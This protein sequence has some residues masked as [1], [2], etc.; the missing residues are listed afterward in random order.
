[1]PLRRPPTEAS[2]PAIVPGV[3]W[4]ITERDQLPLS[5]RLEATATPLPISERGKMRAR[6][7]RDAIFGR[8]VAI[9]T[10]LATR[11]PRCIRLDNDHVHG[12]QPSNGH[13]P[14]K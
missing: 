12:T 7:C 13:N 6:R 11:D 2:Q 14:T 5:L 1:M 10:L 9:W 4:Y 8:R 3:S